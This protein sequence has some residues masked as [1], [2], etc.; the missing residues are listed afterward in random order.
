MTITQGVKITLRNANGAGIQHKN[1]MGVYVCTVI[2][3]NFIQETIL[4]IKM[5]Q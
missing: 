2:V 4:G 3:I 5:L 1:T